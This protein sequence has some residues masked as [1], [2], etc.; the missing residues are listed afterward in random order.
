VGIGVN[1]NMTKEMM[2]REMGEVVEIATSLMDALRREIDRARF[3]ADLINELESWYKR[4]LNYGKPHILKEWMQRRGAINIRVQ[5]KFGERVVEGIA[6]GIDEYGYL[7][8]NKDDR[9]TEKIISGD[10]IL[11]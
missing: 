5:V 4:F 7:L 3:A 1:L 6:S 11:L 8:V 9:T 2:K 10:V